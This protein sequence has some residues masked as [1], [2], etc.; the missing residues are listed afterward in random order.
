M[1][2]N[3]FPLVADGIAI[4]DP[5]KQMALYENEDLI[6][7]IRGYYQDK[8]YDDIARNEEFTAKATSR[9]APSSKRFCSNDEKHHYVKEAR[10]K[11]KQDLKEKRQAYLA[12]E[13]AYVPK[14]VSKK[15]QPAD[16]SPYQKQATTEMSR[17]TKKLHQD[18]Y[19]L[20]ELPKEY[21]EPK[22]LPQQGTTKKNNYDFLKSS[23]IY[24]NKEM[25]QQREKTIAQELNLS[26]FED[27]P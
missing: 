14:Q 19:I 13:M 20:A 3:Q 10:Q 22:N 15:Q 27:L 12:K 1:V 18:N 23:Q 26:R 9:Q 5:A 11:A 8:E 2:K 4:S 24:N 21:K 7:N 25:R 16:S 6:T 17:F